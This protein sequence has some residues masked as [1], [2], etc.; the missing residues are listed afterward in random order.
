MYFASCMPTAKYILILCI[1]DSIGSGIERCR[2]ELKKLSERANQLPAH[3]EITPEFSWNE[4]EEYLL[5]HKIKSC[6]QSC[7]SHSIELG[8]PYLDKFNQL[9]AI[10]YKNDP[11]LEQC[12]SLFKELFTQEKMPEPYPG[13]IVGKQIRKQ[14]FIKAMNRAK[15]MD[16]SLSFWGD[17]LSLYK[18]ENG[19][20]WSCRYV[21][22]LD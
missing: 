10:S 14:H 17:K 1:P 16:C 18:E 7:F 5:V 2:Q 15:E 13:F 11:Q 4:K 12:R 6:V 8:D 19:T 21:F 3:L 22:D 20:E 9:I